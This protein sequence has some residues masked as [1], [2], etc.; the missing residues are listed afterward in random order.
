MKDYKIGWVFDS[1][2]G[3]YFVTINGHEVAFKETEESRDKH[4]VELKIALATVEKE[5][6]WQQ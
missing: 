6:K 3:G 4:I 2:Y 5:E 1:N